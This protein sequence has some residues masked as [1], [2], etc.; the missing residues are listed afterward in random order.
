MPTR[1]DYLMPAE[2]SPWIPLHASLPNGPHQLV[3]ATRR[4]GGEFYSFVKVR[5]SPVP[6]DTKES[7]EVVYTNELDSDW[8]RLA[9]D[10]HVADN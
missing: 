4:Q 5:L 2:P 9:F 1:K 8:S 6:H 3:L 10:V 7:Y